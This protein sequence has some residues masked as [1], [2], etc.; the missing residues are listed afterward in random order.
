MRQ[1][2]ERCSRGLR[3]RQPLDS[4]TEVRVMTSRYV[5]PRSLVTALSTA[6]TTYH[7]AVDG[8]LGSTGGTAPS[9]CS[10]AHPHRTTTLPQPRYLPGNCR[11][12][13][14]PRRP[15]PA[16]SPADRSTAATGAVTRLVPHL[17]PVGRRRDRHVRRR[18]QRPDRRLHGRSARRADGGRR[19]PHELRIWAPSSSSRP[20]PARPTG[21]RSTPTTSDI[22]GTSFGP[23]TPTTP[24]R[25]RRRTTSPMP[26]PSRDRS[27]SRL[28]VSTS[29]RRTSRTSPTSY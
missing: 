13:C 26:R 1:R 17:D 10:S 7:I 16:A 12:P 11:S 15:S 14:R 18:D 23:F 24:P 27:R 21:S 25:F 8:F 20:R 4:L 9:T 22:F 19:R 3:R 2:I 29:A 28:P 6:G 5:A